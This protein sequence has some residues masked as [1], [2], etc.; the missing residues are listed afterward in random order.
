MRTLP[1]KTRKP[2]H[3]GAILREDVLPELRAK[4]DMTQR[5]FAKRLGVSRRTISEIIHERRA[6]TPDMAVRLAHFLD[7][8]AASWLNM[9]QAFDV[10]ELETQ[11]ATVYAHIEKYTRSGHHHSHHHQ[12]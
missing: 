10:W 6:I 2:T 8:T 12:R 9:Q 5:E 1:I 11:H 7:T 3:P 4:F